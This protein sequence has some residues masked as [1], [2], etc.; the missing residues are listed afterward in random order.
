MSMDS[1]LELFV[2]LNVDAGSELDLRKNI[3][4]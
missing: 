2:G 4:I 1:F 3:A